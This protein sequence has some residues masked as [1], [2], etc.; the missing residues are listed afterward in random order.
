MKK[1]N[2]LDPWVEGYIDYLR[3]VRRLTVAT[4]RDYRCALRRI[5]EFLQK[6][7]PGVPLWKC[8]L[9]DCLAWLTQSREAGY[10]DTGLAKELSHV[11]GFLEYSCRSGRCERNVLDGFSL[12]E[13]VRPRAPTVLTLDEAERLVKAL[14]RA[15]A[16]SR[17]CRL[18]V[19]LLYGC[20]LRTNELCQLDLGDVNIERQEIFVRRGKGERQRYV[21]V[22]SAVWVE[23]LAYL[24]ERGGKRG[25]L[26]QT[27][28]KKRRLDCMHVG[29]IV[30]TAAQRA[31]IDWKVTP[32]TLRHTYGTHLMDRGVDVGVI[33][34][35]M[36]HR[37]PGE[38]GV[39]LHGL[40]GRQEQAVDLL[41]VKAVLS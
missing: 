31:A 20:G 36:G 11:R 8:A 30:K 32:K 3:D 29:D 4:L 13:R 19:L 35:L 33:S 21:P 22:P 16:E 27:S 2:R 39:Y 17:R 18:I 7:R 28:H 26:F 38:T 1:T 5:S 37:S 34:T 6:R 10:H 24:T 9:S 15:N 23:L 40:P 25:P 41:P 14:S 12:N